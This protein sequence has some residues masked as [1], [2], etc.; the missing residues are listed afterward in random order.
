MSPCARSLK[1]LRSQEFLAAPVERFIVQV[2]RKIDLFGVGDVLAV[3]PRDKVFLLVQSTTAA[4]V[5]DR[6]ARCWQRSELA[7]WL[8]AGGL[9]EVHGWAKVRDR[10]EVRRVAVRG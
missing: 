10:W 8:Q 1:L 9:F 2:Q 3:H 6:L 7:T 4:H 5:A